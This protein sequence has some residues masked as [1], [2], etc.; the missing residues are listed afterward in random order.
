VIG[1]EPAIEEPLP[2]IKEPWVV[3]AHPKPHCAVAIAAVNP[4]N[5]GRQFLALVRTASFERQEQFRR[6]IPKPDDVG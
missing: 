1:G 4:V 2:P 3:L 6:P 5:N